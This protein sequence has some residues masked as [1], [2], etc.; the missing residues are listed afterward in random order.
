[1]EEN[2]LSKLTVKRH[3]GVKRHKKLLDITVKPLNVELYKL[4]TSHIIKI[5]D[6]VAK[7]VDNVKLLKYECAGDIL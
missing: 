4:K 2:K 1:M 7:T 5:K 6:I 3:N